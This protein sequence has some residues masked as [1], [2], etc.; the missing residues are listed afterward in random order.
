[1]SGRPQKPVAVHRAFKP[2]VPFLF[3]TRLHIFAKLV[4]SHDKRQGTTSVVSIK[5]KKRSGFSLCGTVSNWMQM[6]DAPPLHIFLKPHSETQ[7]APEYLFMFPQTHSEPQEASGHDFSRAD[8]AQKKKWA[9]APACFCLFQI[10]RPKR[11]FVPPVY[12]TRLHRIVLDIRTML[13]KALVIKDAR[14]R[15]ST[16]PYLATKTKF[17]VCAKRK[18]AFYQLHRLFNTHFPRNRHQNVNMI[19]HDDEVVNGNFSIPHVDSKDLDKKFRHTIR[20]E[21]RSS[22]CRSRSYEKRAR[23]K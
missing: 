19:G 11:I 14:I 17:L 6:F 12:Q 23:V 21:E 2:S 22:A 15:I 5:L 8:E 4:R 10:C 3:R 13:L 9:L 1:M 16:L 7:Q 20:L 18:P